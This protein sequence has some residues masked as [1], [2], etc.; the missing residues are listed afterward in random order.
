MVA[1]ADTIE[2]GSVRSKVFV[3]CARRPGVLDHLANRN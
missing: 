2:H 1:V 3:D